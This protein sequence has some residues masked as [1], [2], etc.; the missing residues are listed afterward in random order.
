MDIRKSEGPRQ[1]LEE[2]A[3]KLADG[4]RISTSQLSSLRNKSRRILSLAME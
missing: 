1:L 3:D 4:G 2:D